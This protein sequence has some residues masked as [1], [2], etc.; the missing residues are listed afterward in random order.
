MKSF[1]YIYGLYEFG[2]LYF[3]PEIMSCREFFSELE[4]ENIGR[5][6]F[7]ESVRKNENIYNHDIELKPLKSFV[8][9]KF[10][11]LISFFRDFLIAD[12]NPEKQTFKDIQL[13]ILA[14]L[15]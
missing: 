8:K 3:T 1:I 10:R 5:D 7:W 13:Y 6:E 11:I 4:R 9:S 12:I 2:E 14:N 15:V